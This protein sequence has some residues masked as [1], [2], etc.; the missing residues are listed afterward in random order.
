[1]F[2]RLTVCTYVVLR[3][4]VAEEYDSDARSSDEESF[5]GEKSSEE[6]EERPKKKQKKQKK[7]RPSTNEATRKV[8]FCYEN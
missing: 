1:M 4:Q 8:K 5:S 2:S 7:E 3:D 6:E